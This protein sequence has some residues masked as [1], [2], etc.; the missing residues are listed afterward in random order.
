[1]IS[2]E[3]LNLEEY[4]K[5][6]K[7]I[8][9]S[10]E[11]PLIKCDLNYP[12]PKEIKFEEYKVKLKNHNKEIE[13]KRY[14]LIGRID[15]PKERIKAKRFYKGDKN[16]HG[17]KY[18][19]KNDKVWL[20]L[21]ENWPSNN[22]HLRSKVFLKEDYLYFKIPRE[23]IGIWYNNNLSN[24]FVILPKY[25][26]LKNSFWEAFGIIIGEMGKKYIAISN[27]APKVINHLID[28][29][30]DSKLINKDSW[31]F[32]LTINCRE[33]KNVEEN[34]ITSKQHWT[35]KLNI[36]INKIK[37]PTL[38]KQF[39]SNVNPN[40]G[41]IEIKFFN[42]SLKYVIDFLIKFVK[43]N[44][45]NNFNYSTAF[46]RGLIAAEGCPGKGSKGDNGLRTIRIAS[47][48]LDERLFYAKVC[49]NIGLNATVYEKR[50]NIEI[51]GIESFIKALK[52]KLFALNEKRN[53]VFIERLNN[54]ETIKAL[55][56][57]KD[58]SLCVNEIVKKLNS[59]NYRNINKSFSKL[60][61][62]GIL[63]RINKKDVGYVYSLKDNPILSD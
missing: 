33:L 43:E 41:K 9:V 7:E 18:I 30:N 13:I 44:V 11:I 14:R 38:Y 56:L 45:G 42:K 60:F 61:N 4:L 50:H 58:K 25:L 57:L 51:F 26:D 54:L 49:K 63:K 53:Q 47:K 52:F 5:N 20:V 46:L 24:E 17:L 8:N 37:G 40:Y 27:T 19:I 2:L 16:R 35:E 39:K 62:C 22:L 48:V 29:F 31:K 12:I 59:K 1:M 28:F 23:H 36:D 10:N 15:Y 3:R 21:R 34:N 55:K 6:F 32:N